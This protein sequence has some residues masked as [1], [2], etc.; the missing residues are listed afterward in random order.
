[1]LASGW[2]PTS[3]GGSD[4]DRLLCDAYPGLSD[5][6]GTPKSTPIVFWNID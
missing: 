4:P 5:V 6:Y 2:V 3:L 1:M